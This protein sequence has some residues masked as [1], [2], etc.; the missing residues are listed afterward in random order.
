MP[1]EVKITT[2]AQKWID[3]LYKVRPRAIGFAWDKASKKMAFRQKTGIHKRYRRKIKDPNPRAGN[4]PGA[5]IRVKAQGKTKLDRK[6][7]SH[8]KLRTIDIWSDVTKTKSE[9]VLRRMIR[10]GPKF[11]VERQYM[12]VPFRNKAGKGVPLPKTR[13][14]AKDP[15][16]LI[17]KNKA[18]WLI[19]EGGTYIPGDPF[20]KNPRGGE[21]I[22][23]LRKK[24]Y[25]RAG[26]INYRYLMQHK[27]LAMNL[28]KVLR[29]ELK[30]ELDMAVA[31]N[32]SG[33]SAV[34]R[35]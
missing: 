1:V 30:R 27:L 6:A 7:G 34:T 28:E 25:H 4:F 8:T 29:V 19:D 35:A 10:G 17:S 23:V 20:G 16:I 9:A 32:M 15:K 26:I 12:Y 22:G 3:A 2:D 31:R 11:P 33:S 24:T 21:W 18:V 14:G 5:V 13:K